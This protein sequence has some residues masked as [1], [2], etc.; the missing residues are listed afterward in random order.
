MLLNLKTGSAAFLA[1]TSAL[2]HSL[3]IV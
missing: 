2:I 1:S 3:K